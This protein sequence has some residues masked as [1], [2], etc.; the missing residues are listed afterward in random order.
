M[1]LLSKLHYKYKVAASTLRSNDN[2]VNELME[3][4]KILIP[5]DF[6]EVIKEQSEIEINVDNKKYIRIWGA[7]GCIE[8][9]NAYK[10]QDNIP[11]S[12]AIADD[13]GGNVLVYATRKSEF[14]LY[15]VAL[16]DLEIDEMQFI[17]RSLSDLLVH[18]HGIHKIID[19][20]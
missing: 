17:A 8:M 7:S 12:L 11:S 19:F 2:E 13:E 16:N 14:G 18:G 6:I 5:N 1:S 10:I 9:N 3:F 20:W 15:I 4:S